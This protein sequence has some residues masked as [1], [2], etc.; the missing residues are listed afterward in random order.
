MRRS[1]LF[2]LIVALVCWLD[3]T[4]PAIPGD[5]RGAFLGALFTGIAAVFG[6]L[7]DKAVDIAIIIYHATVIVGRALWDV[8][9]RIAGVFRDTYGFLQRFWSRVLRPF[10]VWAWQSIER[11]AGWLRR[12][13]QPVLDFLI[14]V[15]REL[16]KVYE[17][18]VRPVLETIGVIRRLLQL[19]AL[20]RFEWA[21]ELDAR[22][23][24]LEERL[25]APIRFALGKI[26]E[27]INVV[28]RVMTLDGLLQR[29]TL[30]QSVIR[31]IG[32]IATIWHGAHSRPVTE[33]DRTAAAAR[34]NY[35]S[36]E[37]VIREAEEYIRRGTGPD[38][39]SIEEAFRDLELRYERAA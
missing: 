37:T 33:A 21:K 5:Y 11:L 38:V 13:F 14:R 30:L 3:A 1:L 35:K 27:L 9:V 2:W 25:L 32:D 18:F 31:D 23:A 6:W 34:D 20:L 15:R 19:L 24:E 22:L 7:A 4:H 16:L 36:G 17:R 29:V 10:V 28:N 12:T 39:E 8:A 26:N